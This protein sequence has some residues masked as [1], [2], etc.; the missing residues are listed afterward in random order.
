M[1]TR[2]LNTYKVTQKAQEMAEGGLVQDCSSKG[3][4]IIWALLCASLCALA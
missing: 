4:P 2:D 1:L 3:F